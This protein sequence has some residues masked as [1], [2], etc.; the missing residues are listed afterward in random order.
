MVTTHRGPHRQ[1]LDRR[2]SLAN[3][4]SAPAIAVSGRRFHSPPCGRPPRDRSPHRA[5]LTTGFE[6]VRCP[7]RWLLRPGPGAGEAGGGARR[8]RSMNRP[9]GAD[10]DLLL[11]YAVL[12]S[13]SVAA[14]P[15]HRP[16]ISGREGSAAA[17]P[18][19]EPSVAD[20]HR[21]DP[22][23][24]QE[25]GHRFQVMLA[26]DHV[27]RCNRAGPDRRSPDGLPRAL[28]ATSPRRGL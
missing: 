7:R 26:V 20:G 3:T 27:G 11:G 21:R 12:E 15:V 8:K 23:K 28:V 22:R 9:V 19:R 14:G 2:A 25:R 13:R 24:A 1:G 5:G 10:A 4:R 16:R 6:G 17:P 18:P